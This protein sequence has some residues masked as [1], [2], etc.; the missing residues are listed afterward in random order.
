MQHIFMICWS[1]LQTAKKLLDLYSRLRELGHPSYLDGV[2]EQMLSCKFTPEE[3][4]E[5]VG[6]KIGRC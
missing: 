5:K 4:N 2:L 6:F 1:C 3:A